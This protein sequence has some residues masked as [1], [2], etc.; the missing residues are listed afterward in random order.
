MHRDW[1][2]VP[3]TGQYVQIL[4]ICPTPF[5]RS[6]DHKWLNLAPTEPNMQT[7]HG[8][9]YSLNHAQLQLSSALSEFNLNPNIYFYFQLKSKFAAAVTL[10]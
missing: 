1:L 8:A 3:A 4:T 7:V 9:H 6:V 5:S 2:A 10:C